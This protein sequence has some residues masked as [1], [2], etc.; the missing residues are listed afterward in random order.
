[1]TTAPT[2]NPSSAPKAG[3]PSAD[4]TNVSP[5][6]LVAGG[7]VPFGTTGTKAGLDGRPLGSPIFV[8]QTPGR[9]VGGQLEAPVAITKQTQ[10]TSTSAV[11][12]FAGLSNRDKANLLA[13]LAQIPGIYK[14]GSEPTAQSLMAMGSAIAPRQ[15]DIDALT[16]VMKYSDTVGED[17][18]LSVDKFFVNKGLAASFFSIPAAKGPSLTPSAA[19]ISE[20]NTQFIDIFNAGADKKIAAAYAKEVQQLEAKQNGSISAQQREDIRLKYIQNAAATRYKTAMAT[21]DTKDDA[22][23]QQGALGMVVSQIRAAHAN[24]GI[25]INDAEIYKKGIQGV[26]SEQALANILNVTRQQAKSL[27]P[28]FKDLIEDGAEVSDLVAPYA[29][30][31]SKIYGKPV[32]QLKPSDFYEVAAGAKAMSPDEYK[33]ALYARPE[34]K[35]TETYK[36]TKQGAL[37]AIVKA[38]GIGPA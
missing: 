36:N 29:S 10:Y 5:D 17:Y 14:A 3:S 16:K 13:K 31:Y 4:A 18:Q 2:P 21:P 26:R 28:A 23:L 30:V 1:M 34:F 25:P 7:G 6:A 8:G 20:L 15:V 27:Y 35:D 37:T 33:K 11:D 38:F 9:Y 12:T 19:L 24:S 32:S 22:L